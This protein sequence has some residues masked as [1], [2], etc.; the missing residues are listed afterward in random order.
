MGFADK[1]AASG[2]SAGCMSVMVIGEQHDK[3]YKDGDWKERKKR[4]LRQLILVVPERP[5][6]HTKQHRCK[7]TLSTPRN[8]NSIPWSIL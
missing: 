6:E 1:T 3:E 4:C 2:Y 5:N 7:E 8:R